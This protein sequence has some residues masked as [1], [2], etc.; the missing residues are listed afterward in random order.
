MANIVT[1]VPDGQA[2]DL[3]TLPQ[4]LVYNGD[5]TLNFVQVAVGDTMYRQ[6]LSYTSGQLTGISAWV[7]Q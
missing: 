1:T 2:I 7:K 4:S 5:G 6:T 3:D